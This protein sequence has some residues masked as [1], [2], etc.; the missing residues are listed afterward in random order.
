[1]TRPIPP[2]IVISHLDAQR[3]EALLDSP[4]ADALDTRALE[5]ELDRA[6]RVAPA[7][8]PADVVSMN[9]TVRI[10]DENTGNTRDITLVYPRE[11]NGDPGRVSVLA[12]IGSALLG[13]RV[14]ATIDWPLP[15]GRSTRLT[16]VALDYQP[17]AAGD[18]HR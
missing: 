18:L 8:M 9:S 2:P 7:A 4:Q 17:E 10:R 5:A 15:G 3:I 13:L 11:A 1:M 6:E 12:P 14:G 16:V